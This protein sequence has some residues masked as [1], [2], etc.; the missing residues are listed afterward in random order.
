M[1][2]PAKNC[3]NS[4]LTFS[5]N[6]LQ[7]IYLQIITSCFN[8]I[9]CLI[10]T[11]MHTQNSKHYNVQIFRAMCVNTVVFWLVPLQRLVGIYQHSEMLCLL[12]D[13][14]QDFNQFQSDRECGCCEL[15]SYR[16]NS[17]Q[18]LHI[19]QSRIIFFFHR[20]KLLLFSC[21][22]PLLLLSFEIWVVL[23]HF[24]SHINYQR[25]CVTYLTVQLVTFIWNFIMCTMQIRH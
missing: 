9:G 12:I 23:D 25:N 16:W 13:Y 2:N 22:C 8:C 6:S 24:Q 17:E 3:M 14:S 19:L 7:C 15:G 20:L 4:P 1:S 18:N 21:Y 10:T 5:T 11:W